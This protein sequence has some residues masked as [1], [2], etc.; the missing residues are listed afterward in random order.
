MKVM[1]RRDSDPF[2]KYWWVLLAGFALAGAWICSPLLDSEG[3]STEAAASTESGL[4]FTQAGLDP[5]SNPNGAPGSALDLSME[6]TGGRHKPEGGAMTSSL[7]Q[8]PEGAAPGAPLSESAPGAGPASDS[9]AA[10]LKQVSEKTADPSG[11]GGQKA[12]KGFTAPKANFGSLSGLGSAGGGGGSGARVGAF[13][14]SVANV[15]LATARGLSGSISNAAPAEV[16]GRM[17]GALKTASL[18]AMKAAGGGDADSAAS[19]AGSFFDGSKAGGS[20]AGVGQSQG[21]SSGVYGSLEAAAANLKANRTDL[22]HFEIKTLPGK[23]VEKMDNGD[24]MKKQLMMVAL[25]MVVMGVAGPMAGMI[26]MQAIPMVT[27]AINQKT[28]AEQAAGKS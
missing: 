21:G 27:T 7:Y 24:E 22:D 12:R 23:P 25:S 17:M 8:A 4:R 15:G 10:S 9:L 18:S 19:A 14:A 26:V 16:K 5:S 6:G 2:R 20:I 3:G 1:V 11:W 13:G 28:A